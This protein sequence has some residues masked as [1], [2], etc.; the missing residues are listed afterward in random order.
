MASKLFALAGFTGLTGLV[1][2]VAAAGCSSS[3][4]SSGGGDD[5]GTA[6]DAKKDSSTTK[7]DADEGDTGPAT[8]PTT[9]AI[10]TSAYPWKPPA[11]D[12]GKCTTDDLNKFVAYLDANDTATYADWKTKSGVSTTCAGCL[13]GPDGT[14]WK[15]FVE[16]N[17]DLAELNVGG[18]IQIASGKE[19]C[20]KSYQNW[21]DCR[22]EACADCPDDSNTL[23]KCL[24]AAS[25]GACKAANDNVIT[26][27]GQ[28]ITDYQDACSGDKFVFEGPIKAQ[29]IAGLTNDG[30]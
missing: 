5:S 16:D 14:T 23:S 3:T 18:C 1:F 30:G 21:F 26:Q 15:P 8:C 12:L 13:F 19:A 10:D 24:S 9:D 7:P 20:G 17:G 22:F 27:C 25:K 6:T 28:E 4:T 29:C 2:T 11:V